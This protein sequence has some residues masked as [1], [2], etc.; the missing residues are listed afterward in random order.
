[1]IGL[2]LVTEMAG[3]VPKTALELYGYHIHIGAVMDAAGLVVDD[4]AE[5]LHDSCLAHF[6][7]RTRMSG[8]ALCTAT[9]ATDAT[10]SFRIS[11]G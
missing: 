1:M 4:F 2:F 10:A 7:R 11:P 3:V 8:K 5:D 9:A 6:T